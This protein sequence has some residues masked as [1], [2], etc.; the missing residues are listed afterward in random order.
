MYSPAFYF[1]I[2]ASHYT[3]VFE[4]RLHLFARIADF[5]EKRD[6]RHDVVYVVCAVVEQP[7]RRLAVPVSDVER[8][9]FQIYIAPRIVVFRSCKAAL[10]TVC[11]ADMAVS[12]IFV[13]ELVVTFRADL[14]IVYQIYALCYSPGIFSIPK[15][16]L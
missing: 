12:E 15:Y 11:L 4:E 8:H 16:A 1:I 9:L 14:Y 13:L 2:T 10:R 7:V 3:H 5:K 6:H